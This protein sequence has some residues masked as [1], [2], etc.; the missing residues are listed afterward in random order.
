M[1]APATKTMR[2][3]GLDWNVPRDGRASEAYEVAT[4]AAYLN[5]IGWAT[6]NGPQPQAWE[7]ARHATR[8]HVISGLLHRIAERQ[9]NEDL[10][11]KFCGGTGYN[12]QHRSNGVCRPCAGH[13]STL[14]RRLESL[15]QDAREIAEHYGLTCYFQG[16]PR[17]CSLY[18]GEAKDMNGSSYN[19]G[20]S[21]V[22]LGR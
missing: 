14:G 1:S 17:G 10:G 19:R 8:L 11:C 5:W 15:R 21:I 13:G 4:T 7:A 22:R 6:E 16:D 2:R 3:G 20:H 9:C 12:D 18:I